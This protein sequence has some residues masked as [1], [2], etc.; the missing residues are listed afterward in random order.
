MKH[1]NSGQLNCKTSL[2]VNGWYY[3]E[4]SFFTPVFAYLERISGRVDDH[5]AMPQGGTAAVQS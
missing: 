5:L 3:L 2:Q 4:N 1:V